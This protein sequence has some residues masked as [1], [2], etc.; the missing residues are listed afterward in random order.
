[1][2]R[3]SRKSR[4]PSWCLLL[5]ILSGLVVMGILILYPEETPL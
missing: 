5:A 1:M 2:T 4:T 3:P